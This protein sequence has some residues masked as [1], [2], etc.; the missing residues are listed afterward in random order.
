[1]NSKK[2]SPAINIVFVLS[3]LLCSIVSAIGGPVIRSKSDVILCTVLA[4]VSAAVFIL[5]FY[6]SLR[7][8]HEE[9]ITLTAIL[10]SL[11]ISILL[12]LMFSEGTIYFFLPKSLSQML[13]SVLGSSTRICNVTYISLAWIVL[14]IFALTRKPG[15]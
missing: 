3:S 8:V 4:L 12:F 10:C 14:D 11:L 9:R 6:F 5:L 1:M 13:Y 2:H 15:K 7:W